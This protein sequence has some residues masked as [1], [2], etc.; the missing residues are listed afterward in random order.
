VVDDCDQRLDAFQVFRVLRHVLARGLQVGD[1]G[2]PLAELRVLLE[3]G[4][5]GGEAAQHILGEVGAVD[6]EDEVLTAA[7]EDL[8]LGLGDLG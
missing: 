8:A 1:E 4:V 2:D 7:L 3:E 6:A 5:E